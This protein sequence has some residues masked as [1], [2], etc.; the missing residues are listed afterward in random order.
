MVVLCVDLEGPEVP[1]VLERGGSMTIGQRQKGACQSQRNA[2]NKNLQWS[3]EG[4]RMVLLAQKRRP[5]GPVIHSVQFEP[6]W[7]FCAFLVSLL[8][9]V[10]TQDD[11]GLSQV[12]IEGRARC[13][14]FRKRA[15][16]M[17]STSPEP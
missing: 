1:G 6:P 16:R 5:C 13:R 15:Q 7:L 3:P 17:L 4:C 12:E 10:H 14:A 8:E 2:L 11:R 9:K